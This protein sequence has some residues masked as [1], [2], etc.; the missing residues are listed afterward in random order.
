MCTSTSIFSDQRRKLLIETSF[1]VY[2]RNILIMII[3][4]LWTGC[5]TCKVFH[6][7]VQDAVF[8]LWIESEIHK[9]EDIKDIMS[10]D[11]MS[12]PG[13]V[14]DEKVIMSGKVPTIDDMVILL[15]KYS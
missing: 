15:K 12:M 14:I 3:K 10:Y 7:V 4:I 5:P 1:L 6:K 8:Q 13:L 2:D 11:I 9:I